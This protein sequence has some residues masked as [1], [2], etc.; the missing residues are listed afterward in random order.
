LV[1]ESSGLMIKNGFSTTVGGK[2]LGHTSGDV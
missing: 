1:G 2:D